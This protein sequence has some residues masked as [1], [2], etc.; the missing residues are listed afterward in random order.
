MAITD[1]SGNRRRT[2]ERNSKPDIWGM[3][4]SEIT[5]AGRLLFNCRKASKPFIAMPTS[6]S[7]DCSTSLRLSRTASSSSTTRILCLVGFAM[8]ELSLQE[9][10][11]HKVQQIAVTVQ[12]RTLPLHLRLRRTNKRATDQFCDCPTLTMQAQGSLRRMN[13]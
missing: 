8:E 9:S 4:R 2:T 6:Y 5:M 10:H 11:Y 13:R 3:F 7:D 1:I 12:N